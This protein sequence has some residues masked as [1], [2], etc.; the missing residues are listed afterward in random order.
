MRQLLRPYLEMAFYEFELRKEDEST[1]PDRHQ[2]G[3]RS[4]RHAAWRPSLTS[5]DLRCQPKS[6]ASGRI[7]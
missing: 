3:P 7:Y 4:E 5:R 2:I 1:Y 6:L